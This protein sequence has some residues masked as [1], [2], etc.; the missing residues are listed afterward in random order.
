M[1]KS[2]S[3]ARVL[4]F[5]LLIVA[6]NEEDEDEGAHTCADTQTWCSVLSLL[7]GV[8]SECRVCA[9]GDGSTMVTEEANEEGREWAVGVGKREVGAGSGG[10][11]REIDNPP[12][13]T[14]PPDALRSRESPNFHMLAACARWCLCCRWV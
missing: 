4:A 8:L 11:K 2:I 1:D 9:V 6:E 3:F 13:L 7:L 12:P 10:G 5:V 14:P